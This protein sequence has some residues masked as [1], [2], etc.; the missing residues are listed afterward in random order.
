MPDATIPEFTEKYFFE[1]ENIG[2][3]QISFQ[4]FVI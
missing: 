4:E 1:S 3:P 2:S